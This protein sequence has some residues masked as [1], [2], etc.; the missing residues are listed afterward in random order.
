MES[1]KEL[2]E[3]IVAATLEIQENYP[4]LVKYLLE[5]TGTRP[6]EKDLHVSHRNLKEYYD[7]L[8]ALVKHYKASHPAPEDR[9]YKHVVN[10]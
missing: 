10:E 7:S 9:F 4:E 3:R 5:I 2:T 6:N 1:R 8:I